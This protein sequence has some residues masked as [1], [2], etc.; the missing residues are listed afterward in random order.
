MGRGLDVVKDEPVKPGNPLLGIED[1][2]EDDSCL[3]EIGMH[4]V[5]PE[6]DGLLLSFS[7]PPSPLA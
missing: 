3:A 6:M 2:A 5:L 4:R 1:T 7:S